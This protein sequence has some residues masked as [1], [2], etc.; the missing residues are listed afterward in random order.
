MRER[1]ARVD[2]YLRDNA[3]SAPISPARA[4]A[5][6]DRDRRRR[7][8]VCAQLCALRGSTHERSLGGVS[9][10]VIALVAARLVSAI[11]CDSQR[12]ITSVLDVRY[13]VASV[14]PYGLRTDA[15][16]NV[17]RSC[18]PREERRPRC[19]TTNQTPFTG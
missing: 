9:G 14:L 5:E 6:I 7:C 18:S 11:Q 4:A 8:R 12:L 3:S 2:S 15:R 10:R 19:S 13:G 1:A 16:S 17:L